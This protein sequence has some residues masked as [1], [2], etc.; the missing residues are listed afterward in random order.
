MTT[1]FEPTQVDPLA[2]L[3][4]EIAERGKGIDEALP[5]VLH[6]VGMRREGVLATLACCRRYLEDDV[7]DVASQR[8]VSMMETILRLPMFGDAAVTCRE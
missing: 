3:V 6:A 1:V 8:A 4:R 2:V 7:D 5:I